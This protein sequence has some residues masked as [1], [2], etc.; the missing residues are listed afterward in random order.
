MQASLPRL[1]RMIS[2]DDLGQGSESIR[3][4]GVRW[5]PPGLAASSVSIDGELA[6]G[7]KSASEKHGKNSSDRKVQGEGEVQ[8]PSKQEGRS[9]SNQS[10]GSTSENQDSESVAEGMEAEEGD[11]VNVE[12]AFAYRA[13]AAGKSLRT[14]S[15]NA[16]PLSGLL[17]VWKYQIT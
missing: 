15:K 2:V 9:T 3:I 13:R 14:K 8:N 5:L 1:V 7:T 10:G 4:L 17:P 12:I 6:S 11:F 16:P